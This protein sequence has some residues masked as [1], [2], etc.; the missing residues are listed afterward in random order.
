MVRSPDNRVKRLLRLEWHIIAG[1]A[2]AVVAVI[3]H[4]L[5]VVEL[6]VLITII[7]VLLALL[8]LRDLRREHQD[9][10]LAASVQEIKATTE[11]VQAALT[12]P[13]A[14]L[15][16]PRDL[17]DESRRF[18]E[19]ARGEMLWFNVC[20]TMF[21]SQQ[22][23]DLMLRPAIENPNVTSIQFV[24]NEGERELWDRY[25][26]PKIQD[27]DGRAIVAEPRW[28]SL[29]ETLS[30]VLADVEPH[31]RTEALLSFWGEPFMSRA[32][33]RQVPRYLFRIQG[34][35]DLIPRLVEL[36]REHRL[37]N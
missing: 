21:R 7:L 16:G 3:A 33:D 22:V 29:P 31:G 23:F 35:S 9:D 25:L 15:V 32:T 19:N 2:A 4:L 17:A 26:V 30:F 13:D 27:C 11:G 6:D 36:E 20:L 28:R 34:H 10:R 18:S 1:I 12:P 24:S 37:G 14:I 5:H 8:L